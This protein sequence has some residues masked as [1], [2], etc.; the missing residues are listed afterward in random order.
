MLL[1]DVDEEFETA[2]QD[3]ERVRVVFI[4]DDVDR[5]VDFDD[6]LVLRDVERDMGAEEY[7]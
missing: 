2:E 5:V 6:V 3:E 4:V 7:S 1:N